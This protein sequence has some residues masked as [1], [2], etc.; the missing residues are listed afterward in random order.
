MY[1]RTSSIGSPNRVRTISDFRIVTRATLRIRNSGGGARAT[2]SPSR[3]RYW[4]R[5]Q[6]RSACDFTPATCFRR[7]TATLFSSHATAHGI[8]LRSSAATSPWVSPNENGTVKSVDPLITGFIENNNY[9][10][11]PADLLVLK[12]G[13]MLI[14][15]DF[16]GA[17]YRVTC[18]GASVGR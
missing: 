9:L 8:G 14:S 11:R 12:D 15:D 2:N 10:G 3:S 13:S 4:G 7:N 17:V 1:P 6:L 5:I 18:D 16:N